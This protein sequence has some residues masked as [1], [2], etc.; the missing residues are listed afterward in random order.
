M[1]SKTDMINT[2]IDL[3]STSIGSDTMSCS[4][5]RE[6]RELRLQM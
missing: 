2:Y 1:A 4:L 5:R 6:P 3:L